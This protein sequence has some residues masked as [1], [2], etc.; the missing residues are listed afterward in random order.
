MSPHI[1][2]MFID[3]EAS[4]KQSPEVVV[5]SRDHFK[6]SNGKE[7]LSKNSALMK[8]I[9]SSNDHGHLRDSEVVERVFGSILSPATDMQTPD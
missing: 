2:P 4:M 1:N 7:P 9:L 5:Q 8:Q 3:N 6:K